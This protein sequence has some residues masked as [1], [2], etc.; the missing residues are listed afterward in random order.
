MHMAEKKVQL[1]R[2]DKV[3]MALP[4]LQSITGKWHG[5]G[6]HQWPVPYGL[7]DGRSDM[8]VGCQ[9]LVHCT[10]DW[11]TQGSN[12][13]QAQE[14]HHLLLVSC[15]CHWWQGKPVPVMKELFMLMLILDLYS[16]QKM[17]PVFNPYPF[18]LIGNCHAPHYHTTC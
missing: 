13:T 10:N 7:K 8:L 4:I 12:I 14:L 3:P 11:I 6:L 5:L 16:L 9:P 17:L 1:R 15:A 2:F 18:S